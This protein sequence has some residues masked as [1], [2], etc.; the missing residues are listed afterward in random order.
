[1][2]SRT[3]TLSAA[4][5]SNNFAAGVAVAPF[6]SRHSLAQRPAISCTHVTFGASGMAMSDLK[7]IMSHKSVKIV[8]ACDV[9]L[10]RAVEFRK[11]CPERRVYQ[12]FRELLEKRRPSVVQRLH[13]R[14]MHAPIG[15]AA[16]Q[17]GL[18]V[19][20]QKPL[21][22]DLYECRRLTELAREKKAVTQMA[23]RFTATRNIEPQ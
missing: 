13:A 16:L 11:I 14:H 7:A 5:F 4:R 1:M 17:R 20:G 3:P 8:A 21:T 12:D 22:H 6:I 10:T 15:V 2:P 9:D 18:N 19:Y 23:S